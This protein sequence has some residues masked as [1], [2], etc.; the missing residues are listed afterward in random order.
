MAVRSIST[1]RIE[2]ERMLTQGL[3]YV[4][5]FINKNYLIGLNV[6][7]VV[8]TKY[9][10][11]QYS[12]VRLF[13]VKKIIYNETDDMNG[14]LTSVYS[15]LHSISAS[16][17][18]IIQAHSD[19]INF[20]IGISSDNDS[21]VAG[22]ILEKGIR[23]NF[24]GSDY[25]NLSGS[26]IKG[27]LKNISISNRTN[28]SSVSVV[29]TLRGEDNMYVQG[30]E[31]FIEALK[32]ETY[33]AIFVSE[34]VAQQDVQQRKKGFEQLYTTLFP[35]QKT[36][37]QYGENS[38]ESI[39]EGVSEGFSTSI[40]RAVSDT[41]T[42]SNSNSSSKSF[43]TSSGFS[44][45][46]SNG[47]SSSY[48]FPEGSSTGENN[49]SNFGANWGTNDSTGTSFST[50]TSWGHSVT[51]GETTTD[52]RQTNI[53]NATTTGDSSSLT[54]N[55]ENKTISNILEHISDHLDRIK[56]NEIYGW[57][58]SGGYFIS[59]SIQTTVVAA[60][61]YRALMTGDESQVESA[62]INTWDMT[63]KSSIDKMLAYLQCGKHPIF[64]I[65]A[66]GE[67]GK[68]NVKSAQMISGK[69]IPIFTGFPRTS[70]SGIIID[71]MA[72]FGQEV[73][74]LSG[75]K[76][77]ANFPLGRVVNKGIVESTRIDLDMEAFR[78]HCFITGSTGSGKSNTV[79]R[80][81][82][83]FIDKN[84]KFLIIEPAKGEYKYVYGKLKETNIFWTNPTVYPML[85]INPFSFPD[86]IH[87]LEHLDRL[88]EIFS[89]CWPL[90]GAMPA[91]LKK[92]VERAYIER[93]WDLVRSI[94]IIRDKNKFPTF[95]ELLEIMPKVINESSYSTQAKG[96]YTGALVTRVESLANGIMGQVFCSS[97]ETPSET[98]FD[99]NTIIDL[100]R[101]GAAETKSLLMGVLVM[102]LNEYRISSATDE[103]VPLRHVTVLE[104]AHNLL[105]NS[106]NT[107][108]SAEG[109]NVMGK[110]V[111]MI[112]N[113]IA[114]M[115]TYGEGFIIVDQSPTAVDISAIKNTNTKIVMRLPEKGDQE[116]V[117]NS[118]ALSPEQI[119]EISRLD[120]GMAVVAQ[121]GW[122]EPV[123]VKVD[124]AT[125]QYYGR[126]E[127]H[128]SD[129]DRRITLGNLA[130]E[131]IHQY[132]DIK[133]DEDATF[134]SGALRR[135]I[136]DSTFS[137]RKKQEYYK[138]IESF[139][140]GYTNA[141]DLSEF[142]MEI[143]ECKGLFDIVPLRLSKDSEMTED[144][145]NIKKQWQKKICDMFDK[146]VLLP[147]PV[148]HEKMQLLRYLCVSLVRSK[149]YPGIT[150]GM[151]K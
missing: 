38:S 1:K 94:N 128:P 33:T 120:I 85:H 17:I 2:Q 77:T 8:E 130:S 117:G 32:G 143:L 92:S 72:S 115:R 134:S 66:M 67:F 122:L 65:P 45:G 37:L 109:V 114:E 27:I 34:P 23:G 5:K 7:P 93:G 6:F 73:L 147:E 86:N 56:E 97:I 125:K 58:L 10:I 63:Q 57:W 39:S 28:I 50:S 13:H 81:L 71:S 51:Q 124:A 88:I 102:K 79:Y 135:I 110:S 12:G 112:S 131:L 99:M 55:Y 100:S 18:L 22:M 64:E 87:I 136:R 42:D 129:R 61:T 103:D 19:S 118:F 133:G 139:V 26:T 105:R 106:S 40:N 96:D 83:N 53:N 89:A 76:P 35:L 113:S 75:K 62:Y 54:L 74:T 49:Q 126:E 98:L 148:S 3:Q 111:E 11:E 146:Y 41:N 80:L 95:T 46:A 137:S 68:Q 123:L 108:G 132:E 84:V 70:V 21:A 104:E 138:K 151:R 60:N 144:D 145:Y 119:R 30:F 150:K 31:K 127:M 82:D 90:Y 142:L 52:T 48:S 14:L 78:A 29:P 101:V 16:A 15:A 107:S 9:N 44:F 47:N 141:V 91:I 36:S 121:N 24:P 25:E 43:G 140:T 20:Y 116:T 69:E 4:D 149:K 59:E